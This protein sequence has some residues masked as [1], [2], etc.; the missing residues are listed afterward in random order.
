MATFPQTGQSH[1]DD[2][3]NLKLDEKVIHLLQKLNINKASGPD[4][5]SC[6]IQIETAD[7]ISPHL[8]YIFEFPLVLQQVQHDWT[9]STIA[10]LFKQEHRQRMQYTPFKRLSMILTLMH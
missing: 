4:I 7:E 6:R 3:Q 1:K 9:T 10:V 2:K 5:I 8:K